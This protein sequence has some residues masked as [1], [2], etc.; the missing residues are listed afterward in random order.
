MGTHCSSHWDA[1]LQ[2]C[3]LREQTAKLKGMQDLSSLPT[4]YFNWALCI[5]RSDPMGKEFL[6]GLQ[7]VSCCSSHGFGPRLEE[8]TGRE[9]AN[10]CPPYQPLAPNPG[11]LSPERAGKQ[12]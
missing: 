5:H 10:A 7:H 3:R 8:A 6:P 9:G 12:T 2:L 4:L 11:T 1:E